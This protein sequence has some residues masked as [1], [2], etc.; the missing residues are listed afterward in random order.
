MGLSIFPSSE[1]RELLRYNH[2]S[3][4]ADAWALQLDWVEEPNIRRNGWSGLVRMSLDTPDGNKIE[5]YIKRQ[6][7][8]NCRTRGHPFRGIPTFRREYQNILILQRIG[9]RCA[10]V[11]FYGEEN[12]REAVLI[13]RGLSEFTDLDEWNRNIC[14]NLSDSD[15]KAT[16][17]SIANVLYLMHSHH[18]QYGC[19]YG[20]H[21]YVRTGFS[22]MD[23]AGNNDRVRLIDVEKMR[24]RMSISRIIK[25]ELEQ[26]YRRTSHWQDEHLQYLLD[27]YIQRFDDP[28]HVSEIV[29][30]V[31][32][33]KHI[34]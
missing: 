27:S 23:Q 31:I 30:S 2:I 33:G 28:K 3:G 18:Y 12:Q 16:L 10:D 17:D 29:S 21:I 24:W 22:Q 20:S 26:F 1:C 4:F 32:P 34:A 5:I 14:P 9:V 19:L 6:C 25:H 7:R 11:L 15:I 13:L 8:H